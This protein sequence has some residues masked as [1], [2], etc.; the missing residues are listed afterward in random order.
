MV[1]S[2]NTRA[3]VGL[4]AAGT[5]PFCVGATVFSAQITGT[6]QPSLWPCPFRALTGLPCPGC[7]ATRAVVLF[8]HG[9][10]RFVHYNPF[11]VVALIAAAVFGVVMLVSQLHGSPRRIP[12]DRLP[13]RSALVVGIACAWCIAL[14]NAETIVQ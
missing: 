9:D 11:W 14:I 2:A 8:A 4:I 1:P 10:P 7:G 6:A 13:W 5:L 3:A 12:V